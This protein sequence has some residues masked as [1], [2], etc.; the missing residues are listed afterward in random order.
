M[1]MVDFGIVG[2]VSRL[3]S[4]YAH[5]RD[6]MRTE[7][8]V[9]ALPDYLLK[10]IGWPDAYAERLARRN[11]MKDAAGSENAGAVRQSG[12]SRRPAHAATGKTSQ[13]GHFK[14]EY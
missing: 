9:G 6:E 4:R 2:T 5:L 12:R 7:R 3:W 14:L 13:N 8:S 1:N 10:D 11:S